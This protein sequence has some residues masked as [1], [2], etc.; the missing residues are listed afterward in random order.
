[1]GVLFIVFGVGAIVVG[2]LGKDFYTA[3]V[4]ALGEFKQKSSKWSGRLVFCL[5]GVLL[6]ALGIKFL[7]DPN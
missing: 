3:D 6:I 1:M 7:M 2:I 5:V 4:I